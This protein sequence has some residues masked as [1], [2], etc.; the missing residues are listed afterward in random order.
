MNL[1]GMGTGGV[2]PRTLPVG[3]PDADRQGSFIAGK[4]H[5]G[6]FW[7]EKF[8]GNWE[9]A[10]YIDDVC[11]GACRGFPDQTQD[12]DP[13]HFIFTELDPVDW[14]ALPVEF[15]GISKYMMAEYRGGNVLEVAPRLYAD[16]ARQFVIDD[17]KVIDPA[18]DPQ[19]VTFGLTDM[20]KT[21]VGRA[22]GYTWESME[23]TRR[24]FVHNP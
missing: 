14:P 1:A 18:Y 9:Y 24:P 23:E 11:I 6:H 12:G 21:D 17:Y 16:N 3:G 4:H 7:T 19:N 8:T 2:F 22:N 10:S 13:N 5:P 15:H 20:Y